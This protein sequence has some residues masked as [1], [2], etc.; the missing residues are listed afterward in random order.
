MRILF[1]FGVVL[2]A[3]A[4]VAAAAE[5]AARS[6]L[7]S[8]PLVLAFGDTWTLLWPD[9]F[10]AFAGSLAG[11]AWTAVADTLLRLPGW[12]LF[13]LPGGV[14]AWLGRPHRHPEGEAPDEAS[15]FLYDELEQRAREEG[16]GPDQD[17]LLG[18]DLD[19]EAGDRD[20]D[21]DAGHDDMGPVTHDGVDETPDDVDLDQGEDDRAP[22]DMDDYQAPEMDPEG[23]WDH[24]ETEGQEPDEGSP[25]DRLATGQATR[26]IPEPPPLGEGQWVAPP[27][28]DGS[29]R[30]D[31]EEK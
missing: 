11:T 7:E 1:P 13:G 2:L 20:P 9:S 22:S 14:L 3:A 24:E 27:P 31:G 28:A 12:L 6:T 17:E 10:K 30:R 23:S 25:R 21:L 18:H 8:P 19:L 4:F 5:M 15:F 26:A 16:Y 29:G